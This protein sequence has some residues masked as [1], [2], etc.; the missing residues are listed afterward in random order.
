MDI[1]ILKRHLLV[2]SGCDEAKPAAKRSKLESEEGEKTIAAFLSSVR[3]LVSLDI[4]DEEIEARFQALKSD[5][6]NTDNEYVKSIL[7]AVYE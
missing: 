2:S 5:L 3:E 1:T 6:L 7:S 4:A